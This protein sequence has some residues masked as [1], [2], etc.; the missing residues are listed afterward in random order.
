M[1][2][3]GNRQRGK[4]MLSSALSTIVYAGETTSLHLRLTQL[5]EILDGANHL[6]G[7]AVLVVIPGHN[8]HLIECRRRSW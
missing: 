6:A 1:Q 7:V 8:L 3:K 4:T 2:K 5:G